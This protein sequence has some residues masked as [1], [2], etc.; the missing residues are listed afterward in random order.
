MEN[1]STV[2]KLL[3]V[4]EEAAPVVQIPIFVGNEMFI[5]TQQDIRRIEDIRHLSYNRLGSH[6]QISPILNQ[7]NAQPFGNHFNSSTAPATQLSA[8]QGLVPTQ[9][10]FPG[11]DIDMEKTPP[12]VVANV[13]KQLS[14]S[15]QSKSSSPY[16]MCYS[17]GT[18]TS[19][20]P[21]QNS[22]DNPHRS[23]DRKN[24]SCQTCTN[25]TSQ[26]CNTEP[27][28]HSATIASNTETRPYTTSRASQ[29][30]PTKKRRESFKKH[31]ANDSSCS[32][33]CSPTQEEL[34]TCGRSLPKPRSRRVRLASPERLRHHRSKSTCS[35]PQVTVPN[36]L[37]EELQA[38][39]RQLEKERQQ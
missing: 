13:S 14:W 35:M 21:K 38:Q 37:Y 12:R 26:A 39:K 9:I 18:S 3:Q 17:I 7:W 29:T 22:D 33:A 2:T 4:S 31:R 10:P 25:T 32:D 30:G 1:N 16:P 8:L 15:K 20:L 36:E 19:A 34:C 11:V 27:R 6:A 28:S 24:C 23:P 5:L